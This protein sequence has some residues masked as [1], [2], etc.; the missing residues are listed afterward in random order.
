MGIANGV[1]MLDDCELMSDIPQDDV[2]MRRWL[3]DRGILTH[4]PLPSLV[5]QRAE[6]S[7]RNGPNR[8]R[9]AKWFE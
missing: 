6:L 2:R 3:R 9:V 7:G 5:T 4:Y 1:P 8:G